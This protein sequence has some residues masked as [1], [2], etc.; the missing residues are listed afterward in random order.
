MEHYDPQ[1]LAWSTCP[2]SKLHIAHARSQSCIFV[3]PLIFLDF[4]PATACP[5]VSAQE[6]LST[7]HWRA[8]LARPPRR[9]KRHSG[10]TLGREVGPEH[11]KAATTLTKAD[12]DCSEFAKTFGLL[13]RALAIKARE[14]SEYC[15]GTICTSAE[16]LY[17]AISSAA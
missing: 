4:W 13:Q 14:Y 7:P 10:A 12:F 5:K 8:Q 6:G 3:A 16:K 15:P 2:P 9:W 17:L 1:Y 11:R